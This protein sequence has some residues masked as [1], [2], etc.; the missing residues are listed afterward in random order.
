MIIILSPS[1]GQEFTGPQPDFFTTPNHLADAQLLI[2]ELRKIDSNGLQELMSISKNIADLNVRRYKDF[3]TPFTLQN[4]KQCFFAFTGDVYGQI[5][6]DRYSDADLD[7][8][9]KHLRILSGLYGCLRPLD[10]LQPYRLE[11]KTKLVSKRGS[12]L[13]QFWGE[14]I[15]AN[16]NQSLQLHDTSLLIN[17][18]STEYFKVIQTK[19]LDAPILTIHFKEI[20]NDKARV[21]AIFAKRARGLMTDYLLQN[22]IGRPE[23]IKKFKAGGYRFSSNASNKNNWVFTR[24]QPQ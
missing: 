7:Y 15:T 14:R 5:K 12:N 1:K 9:Q 24:P 6:T 20:K 3:S 8:A 17:L 4:A 2:N 19:K 18:A 11:M 10:L 13:Y 22:R 23:E 21:I 16:L